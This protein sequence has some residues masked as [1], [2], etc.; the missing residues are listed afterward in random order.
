MDKSAGYLLTHQ[1]A[2]VLGIPKRTLTHRVRTGQI[3]E[4]KVSESGYYLWT[5]EDVRLIQTLALETIETKG[6]TLA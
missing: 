3:P 5:A 1:V 6:F 4:P 2:K